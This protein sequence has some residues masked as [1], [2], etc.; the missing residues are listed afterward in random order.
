VNLNKGNPESARFFN[1]ARVLSALRHGTVQSRVDLAR[2][3]TLSKMTISDVISSLIEEGIV[4]ETGEG[5]SLSMGG[6]KPILLRLNPN[7][8]YVIGLDIGRTN[9]IVA[10]GN[11]LGE[12]VEKISVPTHRKHDIN[13]ILVQI[14]KLVDTVLAKAKKPKSSIRGVGISIGGLIDGGTGYVAFSPDFGWKE[15]AFRELVEEKLALPVVVDNCT[16]VMAFGERW[17]DKSSALENAFYINLGY[18]I[19]SAL[20]VN[21]RIYANNSEFGHV[22]I[23]NRDILCECGKKG[24]LEAVASGHAIERIAGGKFETDAKAPGGSAKEIAELALAGNEEAI[25]IFADVGRYLGR[26]ISMAVMLFNPGR[27]VIAGGVASARALFEK[28]MMAEYEENTIEAIKKSTSIQCSV[29][30]MDAGIN[31]AVAIALNYFV[32]HEEA[33]FTD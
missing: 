14:E 27:V 5:E 22:K 32:F 8:H 29:Y 26:A 7:D 33:L 9:A 3:L 2:Q 17:H 20:V 23:T 31:G 4:E 11:L 13:S 15:V 10:L 1:R 21:G 30:G 18:G 24:C 12:C 25:Q 6:R 16:R 19:G 28:S